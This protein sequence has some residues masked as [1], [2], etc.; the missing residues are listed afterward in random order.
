LFRDLS[1]VTITIYYLCTTL[2][3]MVVVFKMQHILIC[4]ILQFH[5]RRLRNNFKMHVFALA[6]VQQQ[7]V[8][9]VKL[10]HVKQ[11]LKLVLVLIID[12]Q[13]WHS[14]FT[15]QQLVNIFIKIWIQFV[16]LY[17][18]KVFSHFRS[19][20]K[21]VNFNYISK[22]LLQVDGFCYYLLESP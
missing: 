19:Q 6:H 14:L 22:K 15:S 12:Y 11:H 2:T 5:P 13:Q 17:K 18:L 3:E 4:T 1:M 7:M 16:F 9:M 10:Y 20:R 21:W 8:L